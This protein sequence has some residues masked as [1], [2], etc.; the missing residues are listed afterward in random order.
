MC[1]HYIKAKTNGRLFVDDIFKYIFLNENVGISIKISS[2]IVP[3]TPINNIVILVHIMAWPRPGDGQL[4]KPVLV[5]LL[6][7]I[8]H[9]VSVCVKCFK[10]THT[11]QKLDLCNAQRFRHFGIIYHPWNI[12]QYD[13]TRP[14]CDLRKHDLRMWPLVLCHK[15]PHN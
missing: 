3:T 6:P 9:S 11:P 1:V 5:R 8:C 10:N 4:S 12:I 15:L 14:L 2:K 13:N 7:H